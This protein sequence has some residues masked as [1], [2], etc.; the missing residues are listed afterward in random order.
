[1]TD[2]RNTPVYRPAFFFFIWL[3]LCL[4]LAPLIIGSIYSPFLRTYTSPAILGFAIG[5][6]LWVVP[7]A[8]V[9]RQAIDLILVAAVL[10]FGTIERIREIILSTVTRSPL[11]VLIIATVTFGFFLAKGR[12]ALRK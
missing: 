11:T 12:E 9:K 10:G 4:A 1:M 8:I 2:S 7:W 6:A 5:L 3:A